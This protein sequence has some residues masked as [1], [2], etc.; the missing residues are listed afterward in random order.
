MHKPNK[1]RVRHQNT[2]RAA[3]VAQLMA[4]QTGY[5]LIE[6]LSRPVAEKVIAENL[7]LWAWTQGRVQFLSPAEI[8][9]AAR[10]GLHSWIEAAVNGSDSADPFF[11]I[12]G[13][14]DA[15]LEIFPSALSIQTR[16]AGAR[17][18]GH[19]CWTY[20]PVF[21]SPK[22]AKAEGF[23]HRIDCGCGRSDKPL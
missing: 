20:G 7:D 19:S 18:G 1:R 12:K 8:R 17:D 6:P 16:C 4:G 22:A 21:V 5:G 9:A 3:A 10:C 23:T 14:W 15:L 13:G 2:E 11:T